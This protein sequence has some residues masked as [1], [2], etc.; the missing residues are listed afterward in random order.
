MGCNENNCKTALNSSNEQFKLKAS[1][2]E[3]SI[4]IK[5]EID[6]IESKKII[7]QRVGSFEE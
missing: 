1:M 6:T 3:E 7:N 2:R 5:T 4:N